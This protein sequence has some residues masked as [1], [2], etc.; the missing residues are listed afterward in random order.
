MGKYLF[1]YLIF[2]LPAAV[3]VYFFSGESSGAAHAFQ[4][5]GAFFLVLG[6]SVNTG[7]LAYHRPRNALAL[8]MGWLGCNILIITALYRTPYQ[9]TLHWWLLNVGGALSFKPLDIFIMALLDFPV[10]HEMVV[11]GALAACCFAGWLC[12]TVY[13]RIRP[14]PYRPRIYRTG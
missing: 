14:N 12:G 7:M 13:R 3:A 10:Q 11:T 8:L 5:F 2:W 9:S 4:W 1:R 6:W